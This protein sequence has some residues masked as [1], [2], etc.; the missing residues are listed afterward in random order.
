MRFKLLTVIP[1]IVMACSTSRSDQSVAVTDTIKS[2][3][4]TMP[5]SVVHTDE[6][7][8]VELTAPTDDSLNTILTQKVDAIADQFKDEMSTCLTLSINLSGYEYRSDI[9]WYFDTLF[10]LRAYYEEWS[11][12]GNSGI[13]HAY[14]EAG[15]IMAIKDEG[16]EGDSH[17]LTLAYVNFPGIIQTDGEEP[18]TRPLQADYLQTRNE[19]LLRQ[20][21]Q[22]L[23]Q[24]QSENPEINND[25]V[26]IHL[27]NN[28]DIGEMNVTETTDCTLEKKL[29]EA[30]TSNL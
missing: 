30:L 17:M 6:S 5:Q 13:R 29:Y 20:L 2:D 7:T 8:P 15:E 1:A 24:I 26:S 18:S 4:P 21:R 10:N 23:Q 3:I 16:Y 28:V 22:T 9:T 25:L 27:E 12:E 19:E 14:F 11:M